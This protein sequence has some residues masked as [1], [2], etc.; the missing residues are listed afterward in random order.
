MRSVRELKD[1]ADEKFK[2]L[3]KATRE[4]IKLE[5]DL[6]LAK[7]RK[8]F[9]NINRLESQLA[10]ARSKR[11]AVRREYNDALREAFGPWVP[12]GKDCTE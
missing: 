9:S 1:K 8:A 4:T 12:Q 6:K 5:E 3:E 7:N 11:E 2:D 10:V